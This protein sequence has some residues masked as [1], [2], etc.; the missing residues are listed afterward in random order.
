MV[1]MSVSIGKLTLQNPV[2]PGSGTFAEGMAKVIDLNGLGAIVTK[3]ITS[4]LREGNTPPRVAELRNSTL[5]SIGIP[6]KG[7]EHYLEELV[8]FYRNYTPPLVAS[9]SANTVEEF[10][11]LAARLSVPGVAAIEANISCPNLKKDGQAFGMDPQATEAVIK[12]MK[13]NTDLQVWAKLSPNVGSIAVIAR[14]AEQGGADALVSSNAI[15][16]MAIDIESHQPK[17]ANLMG[18]ITG[19]A[20]KPILLR[21]AYQAAQAVSIPVIG[22]GGI[23]TAEDAIEYLLAGCTAVQV[24]TA[25][26]ISTS[27]MPRVIDDLQAYCVRRGITRIRDLVGAMK[28]HEAKLLEARAGL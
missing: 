28:V 13:R 10:G 27:A 9:I 19:S 2:M 3:T 22:C 17:V 23:A 12:A 20:T 6:S 5:F 21:M 11:E 18:G 1:D 14:A 15:L 25:N 26:F 16:A 7:P 24:G 4:D 8:P